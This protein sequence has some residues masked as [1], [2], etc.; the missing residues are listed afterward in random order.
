[1]RRPLSPVPRRR[2]AGRLLAS[3]IAAMA[4]AE[5]LGMA[6]AQPAPDALAAVAHIDERARAIGKE[7]RC[8]VCQNQSIDESNAPLALDLKQLLRERLQAGDSDAQAKAFLV[9]RYGNFVLLK[10]PFQTNTL[11]LWL[12]PLLLLG[13]AGLILRRYFTPAA[14]AP[15]AAPQMSADELKRVDEMLGKGGNQ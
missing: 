4:I 1:M 12:G 9:A 7:L 13:L 8:V 10:P 15:P 3:C 6:T 11:L 2:T 5:P 14:A